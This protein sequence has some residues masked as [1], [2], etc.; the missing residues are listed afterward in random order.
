MFGLEGKRVL[1]IIFDPITSFDE[2]TCL[3]P[4]THGEVLEELRTRTS[5]D[6]N[7]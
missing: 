3:L 2:R 1:F 7:L 4:R 6:R 5:E